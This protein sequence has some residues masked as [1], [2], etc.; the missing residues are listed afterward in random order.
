LLMGP[1]AASA[2]F[3]EP[4]ERALG[5]P[6]QPEAAA[7]TLAAGAA[8]TAWHDVARSLGR[9]AGRVTEPL[10]AAVGLAR[11][12]GTMLRIFEPHTRL[13]AEKATAFPTVEGTPFAVTLWQGN[14]LAAESNAWLGGIAS[15][16]ERSGELVL[17]TKLSADGRLDARLE[18]PTGKALDVRLSPAEPSAEERAVLVE[19][20]PWQVT[21]PEN[22]GLLTKM[23]KFFGS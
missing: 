12:D 17:R 5:R 1:L 23:K 3:R 10:T 21:T 6:V 14:A 11:R 7:G 2:W 22:T 15:V 16:A 20:S 9:P 8:I 19:R 18:S 13:P 4:L